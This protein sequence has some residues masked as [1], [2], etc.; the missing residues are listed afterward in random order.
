MVLLTCKPSAAHPEPA[1]PSARA[2]GI[3]GSLVLPLHA[4][5]GHFAA[6]FSCPRPSPSRGPSATTI[7]SNSFGAESALLLASEQTW[8]APKP[9][10]ARRAPR[11]RAVRREG[12]VAARCHG[13]TRRTDWSWPGGSKAARGGRD[14][15]STALRPEPCST[16]ARACERAN[17]GKEHL[18]RL[19]RRGANLLSAGGRAQSLRREVTPLRLRSVESQSSRPI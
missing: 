15:R 18:A 12:Q 4:A 3:E 1:S 13:S 8:G 19:L 10:H 16:R 7:I 5:G 2:N 17:S 6:F 11:E 9:A 14:Q